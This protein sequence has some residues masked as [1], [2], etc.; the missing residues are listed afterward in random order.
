MPLELRELRALHE[1]VLS[2]FCKEAFFP[3]LDLNDSW[4]MFDNLSEEEHRE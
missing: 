3:H 1:N 2:N 4:R